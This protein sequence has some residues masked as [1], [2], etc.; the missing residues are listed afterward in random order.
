MTNKKQNKLLKRPDEFQKFFLRFFVSLRDNERAIALVLAPFLLLGIGIGVWQYYRA[1]QH[2]NRSEELAAIS[3]LFDKEEKDF[4]KQQKALREQISALKKPLDSEKDEKKKSESKAKIERLEKQLKAS[5][6]DHSKSLA[7]YTAFFES[8]DSKP[9]GWQAGIS[10]V[11]ILLDSESLEEAAKILSKVLERSLGID[12]YQVQVRLMYVSVL[13]DLKRHEEALEHFDILMSVAP[14][15][16]KA[17]ILHSKA[18]LLLKAE[19]K[20]E[21]HKVLETLLSEYPSSP[22]ARQAAAIKSI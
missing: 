10:A 8:Y 1:A 20:E 22:E 16:K 19:K 2:E 9:L 14:D 5:K 6:A 18:R 17:L 4:G 3:K 12:F 21:A 15:D 11:N 7:S 13:E